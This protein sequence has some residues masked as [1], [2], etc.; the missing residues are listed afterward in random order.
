MRTAL[1]LSML[2]ITT[3]CSR[4]NTGPALDADPEHLK[5]WTSMSDPVL[6]I[7]LVLN[8]LTLPVG[9]NPYASSATCGPYVMVTDDGMTTH[10]MGSGC[11]DEFGGRYVGSATIER[12]ASGDR[13]ITYDGFGVAG[14]TEEKIILTGTFAAHVASPTTLQFDANLTLTGS[15]LVGQTITIRYSG[16]VIGML[17]DG[18]SV[19]N[20]SGTVQSSGDRPPTGVVTVTHTNL[21]YARD[22][23]LTTLADGVH[24]IVVMYSSSDPRWSYDGV[25]Q[26][27]LP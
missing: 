17:L 13:T 18:R 12:T 20:G 22:S 9:H 5:F 14:G 16:T 24:T 15:A 3:A 2:F 4:S 1:L 27:R 26:G 7:E 23:G 10:E 19:W 6:I 11:A 25:D 8:E 21:V